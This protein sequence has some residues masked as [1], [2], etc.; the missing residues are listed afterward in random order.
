MPKNLL[1]ALLLEPK[2]MLSR[3]S[4]SWCDFVDTAFQSNGIKGGGIVEC[5]HREPRLVG[6]ASSFSG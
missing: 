4:Q 2:K 6:H 1:E 3:P 5:N